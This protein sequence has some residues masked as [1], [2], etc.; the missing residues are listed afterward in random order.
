MHFANLGEYPDG[1]PSASPSLP[2]GS[3]VRIDGDNF[4]DIDNEPSQIES[5][6][7]DVV[8]IKSDGEFAYWSFKNSFVVKQFEFSSNSGN[9][10]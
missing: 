10:C 8:S 1:C 7:T 6:Q 3:I 5:T 9:A 4:A 2:T